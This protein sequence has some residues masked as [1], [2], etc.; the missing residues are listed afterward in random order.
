MELGRGG[1]VALDDW[2]A[3]AE[4]VGLDLVLVPADGAP[5]VA[6]ISDRHRVVIDAATKGGWSGCTRAGTD[7]DLV[8]FETT[9]ARTVK[10]SLRLPEVCVVHVWDVV[11]GVSAPIDAL[12][13]AVDRASGLQTQPASTSGLVIVPATYG[14]RRRM[15]EARDQL[16][17]AFP[18]TG[19]DWFAALTMASRPMPQAPGIL[20]AFPD[21]SGLRPAP[22]LP[23]WMWSHP[24]D[25]PR[26]GRRR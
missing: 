18:T 7:P 14:N 11:T 13:Q 10:P 21:R 15:T 8:P 24:V 26:V 16:A 9:L 19:R 4:A 3:A 12:R 25:G 1:G 6:P 17:A 5:Y 20:W 2:A 22:L 23:G